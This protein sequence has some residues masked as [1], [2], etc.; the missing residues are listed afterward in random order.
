MSSIVHRCYS[1]IIITCHNEDIF[2]PLQPLQPLQDALLIFITQTTQ[3]TMHHTSWSPYEI[4]HSY[5][6]QALAFKSYALTK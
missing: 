1:R 6:S 2:A 3:S 4:H 5:I